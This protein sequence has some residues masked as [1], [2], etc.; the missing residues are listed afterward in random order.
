MRIILAVA[1]LGV[2]LLL[3]GCSHSNQAA[4][5]KPRPSPLPQMSKASWVKPPQPPVRKLLEPTKASSVKPPPLPVRK[6][7]EPT[8]VSSLKPPPLPVR[9][10][11]QGPGVVGEEAAKFK[12]AQER[13]AKVGV[14][15]LTKKDIDGLSY[16]QIKELRGY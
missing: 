16:E 5:A 15:N 13:A 3:G 6:L 10:P 1:V 7:P 4:Y 2:S 8:K 9:K 12:A 11:Q 14:E